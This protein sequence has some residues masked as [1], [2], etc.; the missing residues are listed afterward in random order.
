MKIGLYQGPSCQGNQRRTFAEI[1]QAATAAGTAGACMVVF[2]ELF[3]SGYN[4]PEIIPEIAQ[5]AGGE[6]DAKLREIA[7]ETHCGICVGWPER[8]G[9]DVYNSAS[10][11]S[12]D[13]DLLGLYRKRQLFGE[14]EKTL[15][16][17]EDQYCLFTLEDRNVGLLICYDIEFPEHARSLAENGADLILVPT[18]NGSEFP[19][20]STCL[21]PARALESAISVAYVNY[22]GT[23]N[24]IT[25]SGQTAAYGPDGAPLCQAGTG[26]CLQI[27][28]IPTRAEF[29]TKALSTQLKDIRKA[30]SL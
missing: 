13:G 11:Y 12:K 3:L 9:Q 15:F 24:D 22:C 1:R 14:M 19:R 29:D 25:Y 28:T 7:H 27:I 20:I 10:V 21:V 30:V 6:W 4:Q 23:E 5:H 8:V 26:E 16:Q 18:A 2:P 17:S